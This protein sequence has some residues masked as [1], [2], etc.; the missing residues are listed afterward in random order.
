MDETSR[1][2][3]RP[4][5]P[6]HRLDPERRLGLPAGRYT[7]P[8]NV[9]MLLAGVAATVAAYGALTLIPESPVTTSLT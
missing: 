4:E 2:A 8:N 6:Y 9:T 7:Q 3:E 1:T 5:L